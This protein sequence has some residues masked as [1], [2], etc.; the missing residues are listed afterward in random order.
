MCITALFGLC[1]F[2]LVCLRLF[3]VFNFQDFDGLVNA[4][5]ENLFRAKRKAFVL[6]GYTRQSSVS[7]PSR[8]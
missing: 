5:R 2:Q 1:S 8:L 4:F 3:V 6:K 7:R